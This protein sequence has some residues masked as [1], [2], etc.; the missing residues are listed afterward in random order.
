MISEIELVWLAGI[1]DGEGHITLHQKQGGFHPIR[2]GFTNTNLA[3]IKEI[4]RLLSALNIFYCCCWMNKSRPQHTP[5]YQIS[6]NRLYEAK[7]LAALL[8]P[9]CKHSEKKIKLE[10]YKDF[11]FPKRRDGRRSNA[12][13]NSHIGG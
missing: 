6:V 1:F 9:Y 5:C 12:I 2:I 4:Q 3:I 10:L 13:A 11:I 7:Y 8:F